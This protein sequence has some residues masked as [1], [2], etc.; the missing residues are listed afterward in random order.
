MPRTREDRTSAEVPRFRA[1]R[2]LWHVGKV[3][4]TPTWTTTKQTNCWP[5]PATFHPQ[6]A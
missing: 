5:A 4:S 2:P 3:R 1:T 6:G